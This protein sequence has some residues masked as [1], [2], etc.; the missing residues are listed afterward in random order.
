MSIAILGP[1]FQDLASNVNSNISSISF[2]FVG[3]SFGYLGGS[4]I[5]GILFDC[6]NH[7]LLLGISMLAT[8]IGLFL[9]PFCKRAVLLAIMMSVFGVSMGVLD[10]GGNV[11]ILDT[12]E[13]RAAPHLQALHFSFALGAFV[14]PILA[15]LALGGIAPAGSPTGTDQANLSAPDPLAAADL[16]AVFG[17]PADM[18]LLWAYTVIGMYIFV[19]FVCILVLFLKRSPGQERTK[20]SAQKSQTAKYHKTLLGLIFFFF[21]FYVGAEVTYGS[22]VFSFATQH[23][24]MKES[25][26]AGVNSVFW[27]AFAACRGMAICFATCLYPGTMI[28]MSNIGSLLSSLLLVLFHKSPVCLWSATA[29]Y[30]AS[31][32]TTFPS[33]ISW[34][35]QYTTIKGKSASLFVVGAALGE[36]VIPAVVGTLQGEYSHLPVVL[37]TSL[38]SALVTALLF[39]VMYKFATS[40]LE[41]TLRKNRKSE[42]QKALLPGFGLNDDEEEDGEAESW[43]DAAFEVIEMSEGLQSSLL[44][45]SRAIPGGD[46]APVSNKHC[47]FDVFVDS[48]PR[49]LG[50]SP[51]KQVIT[52][53]E[54]ND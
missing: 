6:M 29:V 42:D 5:G 31:M 10:T 37:Y 3:R 32:A 39:P 36:M 22:Y 2:I 48:S 4:V 28:V 16:E 14:A 21:F 25:E 18:N 13:Q 54:K 8:A 30:G 9:V 24:H 23:V 20:A 19:V 15:K 35:E 41:R 26:A 1:T 50:N 27:G 51:K 38:G 44:E 53:R 17:L 49:I 46:P 43:N 11:L 7:F 33:G 45:P 52:D 12:W 34:I 40:P 47:S